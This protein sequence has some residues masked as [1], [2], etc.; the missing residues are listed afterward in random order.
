MTKIYDRIPE[1]R[2]GNNTRRLIFDRVEYWIIHRISLA[3]QHLLDENL[4][5]PALARAFSDVAMGTG[6]AIPYHFLI[7]QDGIIEQLIPLSLRGAHAKGYNSKS[8][9]VGVVGDFTKHDPTPLQWD[10]LTWL[11]RTM[12]PINGGL[13]IVGHTDLAGS[14]GDSKKVCPGQYLSVTQLYKNIS[15]HRTASEAGAVI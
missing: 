10:L 2:N 4:D 15:S 6:K 12:Y 14:S 1:C 11:S 5:G 3:D 7:L 8:W 13:S 9:A